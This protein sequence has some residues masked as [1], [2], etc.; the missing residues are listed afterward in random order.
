MSRVINSCRNCSIL[1]KSQNNFTDFDLISAETT[2]QSATEAKMCQVVVVWTVSSATAIRVSSESLCT[3]LDNV[4]TTLTTRSRTEAVGT[5]TQATKEY[6]SIP[7][8]TELIT[9]Y[10]EKVTH[11]MDPVLEPKPGYFLLQN[12]S[13]SSVQCAAIWHL[14]LKNASSNN[15]LP[16]SQF[17]EDKRVSN[18]GEE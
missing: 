1:P 2:Q 10:Y 9:E 3:A 8:G 12:L 5:R 7:V 15:V 11:T 6:Q 18:T 14:F 16:I 17:N 13:L 4:S